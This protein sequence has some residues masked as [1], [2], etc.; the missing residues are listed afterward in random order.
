MDKKQKENINI[1]VLIVIL[2]VGVFILSKL[3]VN[4]YNAKPVANGQWLESYTQAR[5]AA[6]ITDQFVSESYLEDYSSPELQDKIKYIAEHSRDAEDAT[7]QV[8]DYVYFNM[9]YQLN[10]PDGVCFNSKAS[11]ILLRGTYNCDTGSRLVRTMLRGMGIATRPVSGCL[12]IS[13]SC[14]MTLAISGID[15]PQYK[16]LTDA[17]LQQ[18]SVSRNGGL[19]AYNEVWLPNS[20]WR[21]IEATAG[22]FADS[23]LC[24]KYLQE[25]IPSSVN[26]ECVSSDP[27]FIRKCRDF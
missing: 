1:L 21:L 19:H 27:L 22:R 18:G 15:L 16:E 2:V 10:E 14:R 13:D 5:V 6:G 23:L 20:N 26:Q 17:D 4:I 25:Y 12:G 3:G 24:A 9:Q 11:D 7:Q 8:L